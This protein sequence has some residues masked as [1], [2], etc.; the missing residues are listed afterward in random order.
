MKPSSH[1]K[2]PD[3]NAVFRRL[4]RFMGPYRK[5]LAVSVVFIILSSLFNSF[6]PFVLGMAT[7]ALAGLVTGGEPVYGEI[8]RFAV[9]LILL[10]SIYI[11]YA[12]FKYIST[13]ILV[14]V[15]QKTIRDLRNG[16]DRKFVKLP[17]NYFDTNTYGD[18]LS[19]SLIHISEPTRH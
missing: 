9:I 4:L 1:N 7:D 13:V 6:G 19:L 11:L 16:I 12:V 10:A 5:G 2:K 17:L 3:P 15:S 18:V 14:R 8:R